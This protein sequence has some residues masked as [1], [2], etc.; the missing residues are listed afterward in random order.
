V[1]PFGVV[2]DGWTPDGVADGRPASGGPWTFSRAS[3]FPDMADVAAAITAEGVR[4]GIW[5][6]SLLYREPP[7]K[8]PIQPWEGGYALD[9]SHP[10]TLELV[11]RDVHQ[12]RDWG[13]ELIKHDFSTFEILR[14]WGF[15]MGPARR[16]M[17][18]SQPTGPVRLRK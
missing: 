11:A 4:P 6:R 5:M 9:P 18:W 17:V 10:A 15:Q 7:T 1:R 2:D 12:I 16:V 3:S 13:F 8:G 14:R